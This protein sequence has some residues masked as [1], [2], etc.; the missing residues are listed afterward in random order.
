MTVFRVSPKQAKS[1]AMA[2]L[3]GNIYNKAINYSMIKVVR[4]YNAKD[5]V[6][7]GN[8]GL[9][10]TCSVIMAGGGGTRFWPLSRKSRPKQ[11]LNLTGSN[12][13]IN[14]T[15]KR[16]DPII[17]AGDTFIV[18]AKSQMNLLKKVLIKDV[19]QENIFLEGVGRNTAPCILYAAMK[20]YK[21][22]GDAIMCV[23]PSD[24]YITDEVE[25]RRVLHK[26]CEAARSSRSLITIGIKPTHPSTGFGYIQYNPYM[27]GEHGYQV[28]RFVE[29]PSYEK[30]SSYISSGSYLWNSGMFIWRISVILECFQRF[31]PA[32][33]EPLD[34]IRDVLWTDEEE[35]VLDELYP[36]LPSI[37]ID[38]GIMEKASNVQVLPGA[39]GWSDVGSWDSLSAI[40]PPDTNGNVV[41]ADHLSLDTK[42][43]IVYG[44]KKLIATVGLQDMIVVSLEDST[45]ICPK[46]RAQ[47]VKNIVS[48]LEQNNRFDIL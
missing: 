13:L 34:Q 39:F 18:T 25:F 2:H 46:S 19:P 15:I 1:A 28:L 4:F 31:L 8:G 7:K 36:R 33:Y 9:M 35:S 24:H 45:L 40:I 32:I 27:E 47:D 22:Y 12:C 48:L 43:T 23:F 20:I 38:Y 5:K 26:A 21:K 6:M 14:Q 16:Q 10:Y 11:Y 44:N 37:S 42:N 30:A 17:P 29:K 41:Q 3:S